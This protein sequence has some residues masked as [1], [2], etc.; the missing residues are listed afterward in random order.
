VKKPAE[1]RSRHGLTAL[2][3]RVAVRGL[4]A[5]DGRTLAAKSLF[6]WRSELLDALGGLPNVSPQKLA[7]VE[8]AVRTKLFLDH[9]DAFLLAQT[10]LIDRRRRAVL[11]I[12]R[13][14][15]ALVDGLSRV[16]AQIGLDRVPRPVQSLAQY[17]ADIDARKNQCEEGE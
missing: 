9:V 2:K 4:A 17:V 10:S 12:L 11:P 15:Q 14:R 16:L 1:R 5:I 8:T 13:E 3:A 7:L 6:A